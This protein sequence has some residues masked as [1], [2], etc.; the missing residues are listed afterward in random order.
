MDTIVLCKMF[1][2]NDPLSE[3]Y[4]LLPLHYPQIGYLTWITNVKNLDQSCAWIKI[5]CHELLKAQNI[6]KDDIKTMTNFLDDQ[7]AK[8]GLTRHDFNVNRIDYD[9]NVA[10]NENEREALFDI[11]GGLPQRVMR[12]DRAKFPQSVYYMCK[13]RH[14]QIYDKVNE[15]IAKGKHIKPWEIDILRQ[16]V[17]CFAPHIRHMK[18]HHKLMP[19]WDNW[20]DLDL[21]AHYLRNAKPIFLKGD[22]YILDQAIDIINSSNLGSA[23]KRNLCDDLKLIAVQ[24]L[25]AMM[26]S[27]SRNSYKDHLNCFEELGISPLTLPARYKHIGKICNPFFK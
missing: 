11:L 21:Q 16:E 25:D 1:H 23:K 3:N 20:V 24:G 10:V 8:I 15:R 7:L 22:F 18:E 17:Q 9:Y 26:E 27:Y 6:S 13:A 14:F 4:K 2:S 19:T 12:M 5:N